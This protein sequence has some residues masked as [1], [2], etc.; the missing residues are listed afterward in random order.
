[1]TTGNIQLTDLDEPATL[2]FP[3]NEGESVATERKQ[4]H[5]ETLSS[6]LV[7]AVRNIDAEN[8]QKAYVITE[9]GDR[10]DWK[11]M[12]VLIKHVQIAGEN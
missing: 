12:L 1:M 7:F 8:K 2:H 10:Y 9:S 4:Q 3:P 11:A 5:F 6:A